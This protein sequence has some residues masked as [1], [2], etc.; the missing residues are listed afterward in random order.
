MIYAENITTKQRILVPKNTPFTMEEYEFVATST[1]DNRDIVFSE[2]SVTDYSATY[3]KVEFTIA[4]LPN[5]GEYK[6]IISN[7]NDIVASG[8]LV[9]TGQETPSVDYIANNEYIQYE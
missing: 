6:Y 2:V 7:H 9:V 1:I 8:I 5:N 4:E 3:Y